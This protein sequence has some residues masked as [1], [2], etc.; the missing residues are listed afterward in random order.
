MTTPGRSG[1]FGGHVRREVPRHPGGRSPFRAGRRRDGTA[2]RRQDS[3]ARAPPPSARP[4]PGSRGSTGSVP[5][6]PSPP[7]STA[8]RAA[9]PSTSSTACCP[10]RSAGRRRMTG[11]SDQVG[12]LLAKPRQ[13]LPLPA[14]MTPRLLATV[15]DQAPGNRSAPPAASHLSATPATR[16]V[17]SAIASPIATPP[18]TCRRR[19]HHTLGIRHRAVLALEADPGSVGAGPRS[20][21]VCALRPAEASAAS[22]SL[23]EHALR[24]PR[25]G[26]VGVGA[27]ERRR[28]ARRGLPRGRGT[29]KFRAPAEGWPSGRRRAPGK[30]VYVK[31]VSWVRIPPHPPF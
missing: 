16:A 26:C 10:E 1:A 17:S 19:F 21:R 28:T 12:C 25:I 31:S 22:C 2:G 13:V 5:G 4:S 20:C 14:R 18:P 30:C 7:A 9:S 11:N 23:P 24:G 29:T 3:V 6:A 15:R 8:W 27:A